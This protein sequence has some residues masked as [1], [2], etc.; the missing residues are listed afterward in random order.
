MVAEKQMCWMKATVRGEGGHGSM[1][2]KG[3][4]MA[5]LAQMLQTLDRRRLPVHVTEPTRQMIETMASVLPPVQKLLMRQLLNP[6]LTDRILDL[7][8]SL[9]GALDPL[10]HNTVSPTILQGSSKTNVIPCEVSVE[11]DGRLLPGRPA[12]EMVSELQALL[13]NKVELAI[14]KHEPGPAEPDMGLFKTL[15]DILCESDPGGTP[16]PL[17]LAGVTDAR[18]F[19]RLGI[20]TYGFTPMRIPP[21]LDVWRLTHGTDERIPVDAMEFGT[22][23]IYKLLHRFGEAG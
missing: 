23:A 6:A 14:V 9:G 10:L 16:G 20:H 12:E 15:G 3:Q 13:G 19:S 4:A 22:E 7:M 8:G 5:K 1:P 11:L 17:V 2:V 21:G 18:H